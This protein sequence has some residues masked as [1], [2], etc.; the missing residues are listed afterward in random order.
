MAIRVGDKAPDFTLFDTE[1]QSKSLKDFAGK[2]TVVAFFP[3]AFTGVCT[4]EM[5][6]FRDSLA[7]FNELKSGV[8]AISV[9]APFS[10][11]A[12]AAQN[13]LKFPIL[14]DYERTV[15]KAYCGVHEDFAG[16]KGYTAAKRSIF[17]V[18]EQ[19]TIKYAWISENP[20]VEPNYDEILKAVS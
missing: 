9:D 7:R 6:A 16:L 2:T 8:V 17:V 10:N 5:C 11:K 3:G 14:S 15:S 4:K 13:D 19:G 20:G 1:K 12:F 18:D